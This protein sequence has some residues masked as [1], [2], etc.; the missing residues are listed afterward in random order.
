MDR[1]QIGT[2]LIVM[3]LR[4]RVDGGRLD[5]DAPNCDGGARGRLLVA[6]VDHSRP[7]GD[8]RQVR[9]LGL[10]GGGSESAN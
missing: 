7:A 10:G 3:L 8:G 1:R 4:E 5:A 6:D 9:E 2:A